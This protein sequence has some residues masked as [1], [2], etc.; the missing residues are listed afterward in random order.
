MI[1][2][3]SN[4]LSRN[5]SASQRKFRIL[6]AHIPGYAAFSTAPVTGSLYPDLGVGALVGAFT[7]GTGTVIK[8]VAIGKQSTTFKVPAGATQLQLG[9][10]DDA[11]DNFGSFSV[12]V[13]VGSAIPTAVAVPGTAQPWRS[14][15]AGL[16]PSLQYAGSSTAD[17]GLGATAAV[18][19]LTGLVTGDI[20]TVAYQSGLVAF[21]FFTHPGYDGDGYPG[22]I[23][24]GTV[25][26]RGPFPTFYMTDP[27]YPW[28]KNIEDIS[29]TVSDLDG[30]ADLSDFIFTVQDAGQA[31]TAEMQYRVFEG[32]RCKLLEG[33]GKFDP[34]N[35]HLVSYDSTFTLADYLTRFLGKVDSVASENNN[36]DYRFTVPDIRKDL[37]K[38]IYQTADDGFPTDQNHRKTILGNPIDILLNILE[39]QIGY[40]ASQIDVAGLTSFRDGPLSGEFFEF[41]LESPPA[42]KDFIENELMK[43]L[44]AYHW[45]D[46]LGVFRVTFFYKIAPTSVQTLDH[47]NLLTVPQAGQADLINQMTFRFDPD[48]GGKFQSESVQN[49]NLSIAKYGLF[50]EHV[51][52]SVGMRA[53]F[54][55]YFLSQFIARLVFLRYGNKQLLIDAIQCD[56]SASLLSPGDITSLTSSLV[57][58]RTNGVLGV[59]AETFEVLD[60]TWS[61]LAGIVTLRILSI[62]LS[63]FKQYLITPNAEAA[64]TLAS[65]TDQGKYLFQCDST[66]RYSDSTPGN[67]LC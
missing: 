39:T 1:S 22:Q 43:P 11:Y 34:N 21:N 14:D 26:L 13:S 32:R 55:G 9:I 2:A 40:S 24:G 35:P 67:T 63:K 66:G 46:N 62:D 3:T 49:W 52:E 28:L 54:Q 19:A 51:V 44:G 16:N 56:W 30:G 23:T 20:V 12:N 59:T 48:S 10:N 65:P 17:I 47:T 31:I 29:L 33:F 41:S 5:A 61:P 27:I 18:V 15:V 45:T 58:D 8:A 25:G 57:P 38:I 64:F 37:T 60:R 4:W 50:G 36:L 6:L 42:A 7:D 53:A